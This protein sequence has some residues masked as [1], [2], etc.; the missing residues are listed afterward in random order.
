M[1]DD[2]KAAVYFCTPKQEFVLSAACLCFLNKV[3]L[4]SKKK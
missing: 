3:S 2:L 4:K 1:L